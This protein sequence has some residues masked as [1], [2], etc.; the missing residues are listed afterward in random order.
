[1]GG[2]VQY[3]PTLTEN[4]QFRKLNHA[5]LNWIESQYLLMPM[6]R[7]DQSEGINMLRELRTSWKAGVEGNYQNFEPLGVK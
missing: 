4:F 1:V 2:S 7:G 6:D 5:S 3:R